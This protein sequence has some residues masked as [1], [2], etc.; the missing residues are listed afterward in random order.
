MKKGSD[1]PNEFE[2]LGEVLAALK[3]LDERQ[4]TWVI[5]SAVTNLGITGSPVSSSPPGAVALGT[6]GIGAI[7][8]TAIPGQPGSNA[9]ARSFLRTRAPKNTV[10]Q[11]ACL[12]F[13]LTHFR[14]TP[15]FKTKDISIMNTDAGG[16][17]I[18]NPSQ[19]VENAAKQSGYLSPAGSG[20]KQLS[21][22]GE[23]VVNALPNQDNV[24]AAEAATPRKKRK[25]SRK[26][27]TKTT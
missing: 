3:D 22:L 21:A 4:R 16:P 18:G 11:V 13:Y 7:A 6:T 12:A 23:D 27:R 25:S 1:K 19:A 9:H 14:N 26:T 24:K 20:K 17:R 8:P 10:Q 5:T 15:H 2:A